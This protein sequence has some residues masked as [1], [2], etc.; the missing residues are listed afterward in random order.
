MWRGAKI[1]LAMMSVLLSI[2]A[3]SH[4]HADQQY[5]PPHIWSDEREAKLFEN[6]FG[7]ELRAMGEPSLWQL[8]KSDRSARIYRMLELPALS[9]GSGARV[10][11]QADGSA[12]LYVTELEIAF[13]GKASKPKEKRVVNLEPLRVRAL[14]A[15]FARSGFWGN[16]IGMTERADG[17]PVHVCLDGIQ[18]VVEALTAGNYKFVTRHICSMENDVFEILKTLAALSGLPEPQRLEF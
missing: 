2:V 12:I 1:R 8:S 14:E 5:T 17:K 9:A 3:A 16:R 18:Y 10:V 6:W 13:D 15:L 7:R 4:V 11:I